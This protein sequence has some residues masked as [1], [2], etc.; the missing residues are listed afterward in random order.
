MHVSLDTMVD[1]LKAAAESSR[2]RILV[3]LSRGDLTVSD[4]TEILGQSQPRVSRHLKLLL[5]A[6][7]IGRYQEGSWAF[8]RLTDTDNSRDFVQRLVS[9]ISETDPQVV[10]DLERLAA[11]K[12]KRQDRAAEYFSENAASWDHI[13]SLHVPDRAV[14]AALLKLVG[15]RP[16]QSML[17]LG[18]GTGR[19]LEIFAPLYRRGVGIDM[20]RE[21][22]TVARANLDKAGIA[23]AQVRQGDIFSP[24]VERNAFDL[25]TI[26]QV[27]HYLDD[28]ARAISEAA[29]LLR[30][31][32]RLIVVDFA[33]HSL[34]FLRD[35]HAHLR[36]GFSDRQMSEWF[37]EAG[38]DLE[39]SQEFGPR[40]GNE[41]RLTVKLWLGRDRRLL[42]AD[43]SNDSL[44][45]RETA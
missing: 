35:Q 18:T 45:A 27:L 10:R 29:R 2:L 43:P 37:E 17:D 33:P 20:S 39:D 22:L 42:I 26:H 31:S 3:L 40:G 8:F 24:P 44:P 25:V 12:R 23:N 11:V 36:L 5:D 9:G 30:P 32:G 34:E 16:F 28:P 4:L 38:L 13:R 7:L 21:M 15:K 14:E 6:G 1:T 19:L 41:A